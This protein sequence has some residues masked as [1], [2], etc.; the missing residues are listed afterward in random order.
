M[1]TPDQNPVEN[2]PKDRPSKKK[3]PHPQ[4]KRSLPENMILLGKSKQAK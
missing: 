4:A 1:D 3:R 2:P